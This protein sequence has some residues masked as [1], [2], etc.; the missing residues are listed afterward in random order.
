M[1]KCDCYSNFSFFLDTSGTVLWLW[2]TSDILRLVCALCLLIP[3]TDF[4]HSRL[5][6]PLLRGGQS[7]IACTCVAMSNSG[8]QRGVLTFVYGYAVSA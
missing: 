4:A 7:S 5:N 2:P 8:M 1:S 6:S 3:R